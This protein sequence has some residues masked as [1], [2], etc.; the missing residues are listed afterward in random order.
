MRKIYLHIGCGKTGS[1][2][3]QLWLNQNAEFFLKRNIYYPIFDV[4]VDDPYKI[5]SGNGVIAV[6]S[7]SDGTFLKFFGNL[8]TK[9]TQDILLSSELFQTLNEKQINEMKNIFNSF[10]MNPSIIVY[11]RDIYD[12]LFSQYNQL[13]KRHVLSKTFHEYV[14]S[15]ISIY[16]FDIIDRWSGFFNNLYVIH[17]DTYKN[18]LDSSFI[19]ALGIN[20]T[21]FPRMRNNTVNR[22]LSFF[23]LELLRLLN[24]IYTAKFKKTNTKFSTNISNFFIKKSPEKSTAILYDEEIEKFIFEKFNKKIKYINETYFKGKNTIQIFNKKDKQFTEEKFVLNNEYKM[25]VTALINMIESFNF[26]DHNSEDKSNKNIS[27]STKNNKIVAFLRD[28]A[29]RNEN[30]NL[31]Y[32]LTLMRAAQALRPDGPLIIKKILEYTNRLG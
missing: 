18:S 21:N 15:I 31:K 27:T 24:E 6:K 12:I 13:V 16:Q 19:S 30:V 29:I 8:I 4:I 5:I 28:E 17:Y 11:L 22:S 23:E 7:I 20:P 1:S 14:L 26:N 25:A 2:A 10:N 9:N 32:S 3:I